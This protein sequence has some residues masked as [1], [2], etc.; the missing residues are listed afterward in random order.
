MSIG[1]RIS[2]ENANLAL[3]IQIDKRRGVTADGRRSVNRAVELDKGYRSGFRP[4][5]R[6]ILRQRETD[7][8]LCVVGFVRSA[9]RHQPVITDAVEP[10]SALDDGCRADIGVPLIL[11]PFENNCFVTVSPILFLFAVCRAPHADGVILFARFAVGGIHNIP[12]FAVVEDI[13]ILDIVPDG[14]LGKPVHDG[15]GR[16]GRVRHRT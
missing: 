1:I 8:I 2:I 5:T 13:R 10:I 11:F 9:V 12:R 6:D 16:A 4:G 15:L 14:R 7:L 3:L